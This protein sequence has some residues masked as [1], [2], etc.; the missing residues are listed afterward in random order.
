MQPTAPS[1]L[2]ALAPSAV[3]VV[4]G[5]SEVAHCARGPA[6]ELPPDVVLGERAVRLMR[7]RRDKRPRGEPWL[8]D[9]G[10]V[11]RGR[12]VYGM[13]TRCAMVRERVIWK[14]RIFELY[15]DA[16]DAQ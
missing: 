12:M 5:F 1:V 16:A 7:P 14:L 15:D 10:V 4:V 9:L 8:R 11:K 6:G 13:P 3:V 2:L